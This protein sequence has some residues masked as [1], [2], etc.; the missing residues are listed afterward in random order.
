MTKRFFAVSLAFILVLFTVF[1]AFAATDTTVTG[2]VLSIDTVTGTFQVGTDAGD[3]LTVTPPAGFDLTTLTV[4]DTVEVQGSLE[5]TDLNA[6]S[7]T[8]APTDGTG[9]GDAET[10][11]TGFYCSNPDAAQPALDKLATQY[12]ADYAQMLDWFCNGHYGVGEIMLALKAS[13]AGGPSAQDLLDMKAELGGWG[14]V[15]L[16]LGTIGHGHDN[17]EAGTV[18][19][20][21]VQTETH[22]NQGANGNASEHS[23]QGSAN[24]GEHGNGGNSGDHG[25]NGHGGGHGH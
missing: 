16:Q 23:N 14:Q 19:E 25:S 7:I 10:G 6:A 1:P 3:T 17:S 13:A 18:G 15:W 5:G 11:N 8:L 4:G 12:G 9:S 22:G 24:A 20:T 2:T 21:E